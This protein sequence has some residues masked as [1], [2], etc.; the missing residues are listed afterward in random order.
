M[1]HRASVFDFF[2]PPGSF[3]RSK[4]LEAISPELVYY[5]FEFL[6]LPSLLDVSHTSR[7]LRDVTQIVVE[8]RCQTVRWFPIKSTKERSMRQSA[9]FNDF[10]RELRRVCAGCQNNLRTFEHPIF[11][12]TWLCEQCKNQPKYA[13]MRVSEARKL[14][15][16]PRYELE[17]SIECTH[18][19]VNSF[20]KTRKYDFWVTSRKV[21]K[22]SRDM[23]GS[24]SPVPIH[25][26]R[27]IN[28]SV[29]IAKRS[30]RYS[31]RYSF[32]RRMTLLGYHKKELQRLQI[33]FIWR[34]R[35]P[36]YHGNP[37]GNSSPKSDVSTE[38]YFTEC[39]A[40]LEELRADYYRFRQYEDDMIQRL[41][42]IEISPF[43]TNRLVESSTFVEINP[44]NF[45]PTLP[46][47]RHAVCAYQ[48]P[49]LESIVEK[50]R[51]SPHLLKPYDDRD[52]YQ[53]PLDWLALV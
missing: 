20:A 18:K 10:A 6:T 47:R 26:A 27:A 33:S 46:S 29:G 22:V 52:L 53:K 12:G 48:S 13:V 31:L 40:V 4:M 16:F 39:I 28:K 36:R 42:E 9:F 32:L 30:L 23:Y 15:H 49:P 2:R 8:R 5:I 51:S 11:A 7:S 17:R 19:R 43:F 35:F 25:V 14:F 37:I 45:H 50:I 1:T 3:V 24:D 38:A 34:H 44:Y 41:R 21:Q